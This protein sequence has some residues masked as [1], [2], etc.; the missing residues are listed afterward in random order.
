MGTLSSC[1]PSQEGVKKQERAEQI[2]S[3]LHAVYDMFNRA[4][5]SIGQ[6]DVVMILFILRQ[7]FNLDFPFPTIPDFY[8]KRPYLMDRYFK[9][10]DVPFD[11]KFQVN[12]TKEEVNGYL[13]N[14][15]GSDIN[16][17]T[18][19]S[20]YCNE[21][22]LDNRFLNTIK[23]TL[24][25]PPPYPD[26][27]DKNIPP[28][29]YWPLHAALQIQGAKY[30][31][32]L[33]SSEEVDILLE[34]IQEKILLISNG[35]I[36]TLRFDQDIITESL[37]MLYYMGLDDQVGEDQIDRL[38]GN[39]LYGGGWSYNSTSDKVSLHTSM[40]AMWVLLEYRESLSD[41]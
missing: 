13:D 39:Q 5:T 38:L 11:G 23:Q 20:M 7:H 27:A 17:L 37:A 8:E 12:Y 3:S 40:L 31:G 6:P 10:Y 26:L 25:D 34:E 1:G 21:Y 24:H 18:F 28:P 16:A 35:D 32:C 22:P 2:D 9:L 41:S 36:Q 33:N 19:W 29:E 30:S 15:L 4:G 14:S